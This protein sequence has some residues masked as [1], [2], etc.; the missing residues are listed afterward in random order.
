LHSEFIPAWAPLALF[1]AGL[2]VL[3]VKA[4]FF[5]RLAVPF[6]AEAQRLELKRRVR[7]W[8]PVTIGALIVALIS[9]GYLNRH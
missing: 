6:G 8:V 4:I 2:F 5:E 9:G 1:G 7:R 3:I